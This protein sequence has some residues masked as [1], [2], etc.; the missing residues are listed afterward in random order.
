[1]VKK[2]WQHKNFKE[3][4]LSA[5]KGLA[6]IL[7]NERNARFIALSALI[8]IAASFFMRLSLREFALVFIVI[9]MVFIS[10]VINSLIEYI[11]DLMHPAHNEM[12]KKLKDASS[13]AVLISAFCSLVVGLLIFIPHFKKIFF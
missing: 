12:I 3:S 6:I 10:E 13:A 8:V 2:S 5:T 4:L 9:A 7:K 11:L 1:M